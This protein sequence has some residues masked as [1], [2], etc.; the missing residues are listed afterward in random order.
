[1]ALSVLMNSTERTGDHA[2]AAELAAVV[3][4]KRY[5]DEGGA[6]LAREHAEPGKLAIRGCDRF[7]PT[8]RMYCRRLRFPAKARLC[9]CGRRGGAHIKDMPLEHRGASEGPSDPA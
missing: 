6:L 4:T 8:P 9:Q 1:M 2:L 5:P 7:G 3:G